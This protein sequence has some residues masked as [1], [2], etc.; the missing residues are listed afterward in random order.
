MI[1][2]GFR[3]PA[4]D[5]DL[6]A[7]ELRARAGVD[8]HIKFTISKYNGLFK[9]PFSYYRY[10]WDAR[11]NVHRPILDSLSEDSRLSF[12]P[13]FDHQSMSKDCIARS[14]VKV[15][16]CSRGFQAQKPLLSEH[17]EHTS[18]KLRTAEKDH[19]T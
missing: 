4:D 5:A 12:R 14:T 16:C 13:D 11:L 15:Q 19:T 3:C 7:L 10:M 8:R 6:F 2:R 1:L 17:A 9:G 18:L